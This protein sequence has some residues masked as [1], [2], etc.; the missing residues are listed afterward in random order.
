[1]P[2]YQYS[3]PRC[4]RSVERLAPLAARNRQECEACGAALVRELSHTAPPVGWPPRGVGA[5][6]ERPGGGWHL[7]HAAPG[8]KTF[9]SR[10]ELRD[11]CKREG[12]QVQDE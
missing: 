4:R 9:Y 6:A 8:G 10:R 2:L 3:C 7:E 12:L 1:M 11:F 5:A